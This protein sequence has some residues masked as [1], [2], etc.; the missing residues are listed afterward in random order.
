MSSVN[1]TAV[2]GTGSH[3]RTWKILVIARKFGRE[4]QGSQV[5]WSENCDGWL[6]TFFP[7]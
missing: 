6:M 4:V 3:M 7:T 5:L 2:T 1:I